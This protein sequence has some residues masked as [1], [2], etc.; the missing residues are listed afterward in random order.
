MS[1]PDAGTWSD[2]EAM[3]TIFKV[4]LIGGFG[5]IALYWIVRLCKYFLD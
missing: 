1:A 2:Y 4:I 3:T 5:W